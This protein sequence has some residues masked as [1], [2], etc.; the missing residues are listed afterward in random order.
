M[1]L[2]L[3]MF[4]VVMLGLVSVTR[5]Y[6]ALVAE[7]YEAVSTPVIQIATETLTLVYQ[8]VRFAAERY[9]TFLTHEAYLY[10]RFARILL[11]WL[12]LLLLVCLL[13]LVHVWDA[14]GCHAG[15]VRSRHDLLE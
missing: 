4:L 8:Q 1:C 9:P 2:A 12:L 13:L 15:L 6:L 11:S 7:L 5:A 3:G 14:E 10:V